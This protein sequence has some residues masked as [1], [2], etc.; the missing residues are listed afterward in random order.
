MKRRFST[1]TYCSI[2]CRT[3]CNLVL[4]LVASTLFFSFL[5]LEC[6]RHLLLAYLHIIFILLLEI[7]PPL[8][9]CEYCSLKLFFA[10]VSN[11]RCFL[12][13]LQRKI[14]CRKIFAGCVSYL[15]SVARLASIVSTFIGLLDFVHYFT[16]SF[17]PPVFL[18]GVDKNGFNL[19]LRCNFRQVFG[20]TYLFWFLPIF[21]S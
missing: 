5:W 2:A 3:P 20:D 12:L 6:L 16:E 7:S 14:D 8:V 19:G 18:Y 21:S 13:F 11:S 9:S 10:D 17:R 1:I 4:V 15:Q